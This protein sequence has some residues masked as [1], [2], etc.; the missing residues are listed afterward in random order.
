MWTEH[1][2]VTGTI[3]V[4]Q[5]VGDAA[6]SPIVKDAGSATQGMAAA[7]IVYRF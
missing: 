4:R 6:D 1:W 7:G 5:L 2:G 3:G